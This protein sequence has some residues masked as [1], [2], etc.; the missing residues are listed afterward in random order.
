MK[1][2][3]FAAGAFTLAMV[4]CAHGQTL[5]I[6]TS[7][8]LRSSVLAEDRTLMVSLPNGYEDSK[9]R[10]PVLVV[11][12][13]EWRFRFLASAVETMADAGAI[14]DMIVVGIVNA[15]RDRDLTPAFDGHGG[16]A[17]GGAE[18]FLRFIQDE[19]LPFVEQRYRTRPYR[20]LLGHSHAGF[21]TLYSLMREPGL[22]NAYI[23]VSPSRGQDDRHVKNLEQ[24][25]SKS[26]RLDTFVYIGHGGK[27]SDDILLGSFRYGRVLGDQADRGLDV[28]VESF[29]FDTHGSVVH[30]S[31]TRALEY[32]SYWTVD[33]PRSADGLLSPDQQRHRAIVERFG[34]DFRRAPPPPVS[35]ARPLMTVLDTRGRQSLAEGL[36]RLRLQAPDSFVF[37][38]VELENLGGHLHGVGRD[39]DARAVLDLLRVA[40]PAEDPRAASANNYGSGVD[41]LRGLAAHY[42]LDGDALDRSGNGNH[43]TIRGAVPAPD[44]HGN[45]AGALYFDGKGSRVEAGNSPSLNLSR[46]L[47]ISAWI[48]PATRRAYSSWVSKVAGGASQWRI[49]FGSGNAQWGL[50]RFTSD[51]KDYFLE[52]SVVPAGAWTHVVA[53]ADQTLGRLTYYLDGRRVGEIDGL[54]AFSPGQGPLLIGEQRDDGVFFE[55]AIDDVRVYNRVLGADE[56]RALRDAR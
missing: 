45:A 52:D 28:R 36:Q 54:A 42:P 41:L 53:C 49:G 25:L 19:V 32:L 43:G 18:N 10:Y 3:L 46:S 30:K 7:Q 35:I 5:T 11:L 16:Y 24:S 31:M 20:I 38:P 40:G 6:G 44:R 21:F 27:E 12:D 34:Y 4:S 55:G 1:K 47:T 9:Q 29:P 48:K 51:W 22:F 2:R 14:P 26:T 17:P 33:F 50:T 39:A 23:A 56:V 15:Q 13:A 8:T 37:D